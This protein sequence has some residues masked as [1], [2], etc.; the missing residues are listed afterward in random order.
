M[1]KT[2]AGD[3]ILVEFATAQQGRTRS[4]YKVNG[5]YCYIVD[6][7]VMPDVMPGETWQ[8]R[9]VA[10]NSRGTM[11]IVQPVRIINSLSGIHHLLSRYEAQYTRGLRAAEAKFSDFA[12][13]HGS[14]DPALALVMAEHVTSKQTKALLPLDYVR[15]SILTAIRIIE[16]TAGEDSTMLVDLLENIASIEMERKDIGAAK[17]HYKRLVR[18]ALE[19]RLIAK[20]EATNLK[21]ARIHYAEG[22]FKSSVARYLDAGPEKALSFEDRFQLAQGFSRIDMPEMSNEVYRRL[23]AALLAELS[24]PRI[25]IDVVMMSEGVPAPTAQNLDALLDKVLKGL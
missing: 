23:T 24:K 5:A 16:G 18:L 6:D 20:L 1:T 11:S 19:H 22:D 14:G 15:D 10:Q 12:K 8:V 13:I 17:S 21:L 25:K 2:N 9:F 7:G 3:I 4:K